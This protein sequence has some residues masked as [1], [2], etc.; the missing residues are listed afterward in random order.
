MYEIELVISAQSIDDAEAALTAIGLS[1]EGIQTIGSVFLVNI[2]LDE[3]IPEDVY[4]K[5]KESET[6]SIVSDSFSP[7]RGEE[8]SRSLY[9]VESHLRRLLLYIPGFA[10][11]YLDIILEKATHYKGEAL[12]SK[13]T[14]LDA[15]TSQLTLGQIIEVFSY[16]TSVDGEKPLTWAK[17][18]DLLEQTDDVASLR[19]KISKKIEPVSVWD[20]ISD[21]VLK[22]PVELGEI[23][24]KLL[25]LKTIR[26]TSA[27]YRIITQ[28]D[29]KEALF[30]SKSLISEL[31]IKELT[32]SDQAA[33]REA[34]KKASDLM[35]ETDIANGGYPANL[36]NAPIDTVVDPWG[37]Y[38][39]ESVSYAAWKVHQN[40]HRMPYWGGRGNANRWPDNARSEGI[41]VGG[42]PKAGCVAI[43]PSGYYGHAM[44]VEEVLPSNQIKVSQYN[45]GNQGTYSEMTMVADGL[46][47]IYFE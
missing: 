22:T 2:L 28:K 3:E 15:L 31:E 12:L 25:R 4:D 38:N 17:L 46:I 19:E 30:L 41:P 21:H 14:S 26:D 16:N 7:K 32:P 39:R 42:T 45:F 13:R 35:K 34:D 11:T 29:V 27:H 44:W 5:I 47:Y 10:E 8:V 20:V 37:M 1:T 9:L 18:L 33:I 6:I 24:S 40:Y 23:S 36:A 43:L